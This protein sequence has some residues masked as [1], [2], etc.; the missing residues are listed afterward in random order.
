MEHRDGIACLVVRSW[1][2]FR[3]GATIVIEADKARRFAALGVLEIIQ[4]KDAGAQEER[5]AE[6]ESAA[7]SEPMKRRRRRSDGA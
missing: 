1:N 6:S 2:G 5:R 3:V 7:E 4:P